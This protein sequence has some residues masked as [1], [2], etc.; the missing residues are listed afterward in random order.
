[1][2]AI[3]SFATILPTL[4]G[5]VGAAQGIIS[6]VN[7][8]Q[9]IVNPDAKDDLALK[10]LRAY[11]NAQQQHFEQQNALEREKMA[12]LGAQEEEERQRALRR[13]VARQRAQFGASGI[14]ATAADGSAE[15]VLLGLF[16][17]SEND[18]SKRAELDNLR[19]QALDMDSSQ[20]R[21]LNLLQATQLAEK[22]KLS[23]LYS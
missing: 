22:Q 19:N 10:Q 7:A 8:V 18:R 5:A 23:T 14:G 11:Q 16:E 4:T 2:G 1:M 12:L 20:K 21:T 15:A 17:E 9:N 13:A 3:H 6:T